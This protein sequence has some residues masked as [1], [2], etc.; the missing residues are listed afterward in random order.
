MST[1]FLFK[2]DM[3]HDLCFELENNQIKYTGHIVEKQFVDDRPYF[4]FYKSENPMNHKMILSHRS[5]YYSKKITTAEIKKVY[6]KEYKKA[7]K[8]LVNNAHTKRENDLHIL[9]P[10]MSF[11]S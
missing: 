8:Y 1:S 3:D 10:D 5:I 7:Y 2:I 9:K 6:P 11:V 4:I